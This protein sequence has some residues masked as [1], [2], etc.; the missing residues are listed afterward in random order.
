MSTLAR[1]QTRARGAG[2]RLGL[3]R[4]LSLAALVVLTAVFSLPTVW[5]VLTSL[6]RET[7]W[8]WRWVQPPNSPMVFTAV[9]NDDQRVVRS[10]STHDRSTDAN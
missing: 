5:L 8:D 9:L 1:E 6:K 3:G 2:R 4:W 7:E 10:G